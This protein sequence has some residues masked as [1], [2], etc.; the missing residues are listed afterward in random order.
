M[1]TVVDG[2]YEADQGILKL[3][4]KLSLADQTRVRISLDP[5]SEPPT[6][7]QKLR[8]HI[9]IDE[10]VARRIVEDEDLNGAE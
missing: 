8:G 3:A 7:A 2:I 9:V 5:L 6:L 1:A 10:R 4:Q